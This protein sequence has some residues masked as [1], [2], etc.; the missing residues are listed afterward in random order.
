MRRRTTFQLDVRLESELSVALVALLE[1]RIA[2][3]VIAQLLPEPWLVVLGEDQPAHPFGAFPEV[4][5]RNKE[6]R[7]SSMLG[8]ELVTVVAV[9]DPRLAAGDVL[10]REVRRVAAVA[11]GSDVAALE[12]HAVQQ[13]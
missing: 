5:V 10:D 9:D 1:P 2:A 7:R 6:A 12:L 8:L 4:Q 3:V 11:Q 13:R